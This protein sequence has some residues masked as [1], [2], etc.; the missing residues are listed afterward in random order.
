MTYSMT[1]S[2]FL[3]QGEAYGM[4]S[5]ANDKSSFFQLCLSSDNLLIDGENSEKSDS[6]SAKR[7]SL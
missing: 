4:T 6:L 3:K 2:T 5:G 7:N 1:L